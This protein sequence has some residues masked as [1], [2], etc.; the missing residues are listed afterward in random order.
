MP[1]KTPTLWAFRYPILHQKG[2]QYVLWRRRMKPRKNKKG[3]WPEI[4][5]H[6]TFD[7]VRTN[8]LL[9]EREYEAI[10]PMYCL[11]LNGGPVEIRFADEE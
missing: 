10:F 7:T 11:P 1:T 2:G 6:E 8:W 4:P 3:N 5:R 9:R